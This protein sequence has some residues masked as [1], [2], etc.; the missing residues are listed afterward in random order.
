MEG[1]VVKEDAEKRRGTEKLRK[2]RE[3]GNNIE[4]NTVDIQEVT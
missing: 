1:H 2:R 3:T 4:R